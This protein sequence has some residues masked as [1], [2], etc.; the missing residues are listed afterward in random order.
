MNYSEEEYTSGRAQQI[1]SRIAADF[2][3]WERDNASF[4]RV[5]KAL[6]TDGGKEIPPEPKL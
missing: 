3:G 6:R 5:I 4:E 2:K 1:R